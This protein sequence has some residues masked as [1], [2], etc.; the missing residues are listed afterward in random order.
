MRAVEGP[1]TKQINKTKT[2][3][4]TNRAIN[5]DVKKKS[6]VFTD[7][8]IQFYYSLQWKC[9]FIRQLFSLTNTNNLIP[10]AAHSQKPNTKQKAD[11]YVLTC[12]GF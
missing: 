7:A 5:D 12:K 4:T 10:L 11:V 3:F 6:Q 9:S 8:S 2:I 1:R